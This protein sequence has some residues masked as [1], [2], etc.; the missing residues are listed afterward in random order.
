ME[1]KP[2]SHLE[3]VDSAMMELKVLE[4]WP[5]E[6]ELRNKPSLVQPFF[7]IKIE[8]DFLASLAVED[9]SLSS[10]PLE[11]L[12]NDNGI[13]IT[14]FVEGSGTFNSDLDSKENIESKSAFKMVLVLFVENTKKN[15]IYY[16]LNFDIK[17]KELLKI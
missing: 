5:L 6:L 8:D 17:M 7:K 1:N 13:A 3:I 11:S 9:L 14:F 16:D 10:Q 15:G 4:Y 2:K 12:E